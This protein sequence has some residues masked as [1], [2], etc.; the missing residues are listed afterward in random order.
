MVK[1]YVVELNIAERQ[2]L[3]GLLNKGKLSVRKVKRA[4]IL[5]AAAKGQIDEQIAATLGVHV[6]TIER[7]RKRF[8]QGGLDKALNE[9]PRPG[10]QM[11]LNDKGEAVLVALACSEAPQGYSAWTMQMLAD[12]LVELGVVDSISDEAVRLRLKKTR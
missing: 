7:T 10:G 6:H 11:K 8:V 3:E 1:R 5:L 12:R 9:D 4:Q 2:E